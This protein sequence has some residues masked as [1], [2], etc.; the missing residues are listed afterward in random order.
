MKALERFKNYREQC[1]ERRLQKIATEIAELLPKQIS[2][3]PEGHYPHPVGPLPRDREPWEHILDVHQR[4][5]AIHIAQ[6]LGEIAI[7]DPHLTQKLSTDADTFV[8][9]KW[10]R[11]KPYLTVVYQAA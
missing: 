1:R 4:V 8:V 5:R 7:L 2:A 11:V 10:D 9:G 6:D 3:D